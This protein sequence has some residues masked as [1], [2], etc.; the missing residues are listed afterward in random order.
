MFNRQVVQHQRP[1][2]D[3]K[4]TIKQCYS[5]DDTFSYELSHTGTYAATWTLKNLSS[6]KKSHPL[7]Y[8]AK[9][10]GVLLTMNSGTHSYQIMPIKAST[11]IRYLN[12]TQKSINKSM[13]RRKLITIFM[14]HNKASG[15]IHLECPFCLIPVLVLAIS[16]YQC[17]DHWAT[18]KANSFLVFPSCEQKCHA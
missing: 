2:F 1:F 15:A 17:S 18:V 5:I 8:K 14:N 16:Q 9:S 4:D 12:V 3:S 6:R 10:S 7:Q 13:L 11:S